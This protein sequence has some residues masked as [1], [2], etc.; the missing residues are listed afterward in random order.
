MLEFSAIRT[1]FIRPRI[2]RALALLS[3][4][5]FTVYTHETSANENQYPAAPELGS[6]PIQTDR[7]VYKVERTAT[8][9]TVSIPFVYTNKTGR[10]VYLPTCNGA[11]PPV[12]EKWV[13]GA[14]IEAYASVALMCQGPPKVVAPGDEYCH[15]FEIL[16]HPRGSNWLPQFAL[17]K[18]RGAYRLVWTIYETWTPNSPEPGLGLVLPLEARVSNTFHFTQ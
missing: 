3:V 12:L 6:T 18:I 5:L 15:T 16:A 10:K 8:G 14:W 13:Q 1:L 7:E 2:G 9:Y 4:A 17:N 11:H